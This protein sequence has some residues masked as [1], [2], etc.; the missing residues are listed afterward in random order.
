ML[1]DQRVFL[2][3]DI[4]KLAKILVGGQQIR[5]CIGKEPCPTRSQQAHQHQVPLHP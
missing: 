5:H 2:K 3:I 4:G 1:Q